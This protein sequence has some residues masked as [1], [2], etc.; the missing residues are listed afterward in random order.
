[1]E[2]LV[3]IVAPQNPIDLLFKVLVLISVF[4]AFDY[5]IGQAM[6]SLT[7]TSL[8]IELLTTL[9]IAA[10]FGFFVMSIMAVQRQLKEKLRHLA[11]TDQLTGL[12]NRQAF[13]A[14]ACKALSKYPSSTILM[15][16]VDHFKAV[17][18]T[19]G[20]FLGDISLR[21]VGNHLTENA[22]AGDVVGRL[23]GEEFAVLL[24]NVD[25]VTAESVSA[26]ICMP[27]NI[28]AT[29]DFDENAPRL[30]LT[31]SVGGVMALPGQDLSELLRHADDALYNAK[32]AGRARAVFHERVEI[33]Q[34]LAC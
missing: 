21:R 2:K 8:M 9:F 1:M 6:K 3:D 30:V 17:N 18:D 27:I 5:F 32:T 7:S 24:T 10:P 34:R 26:R 22:R 25:R 31:M 14:R 11:E 29:G 12:A 4:T 15:V 20:H 19:Y 33:D 13:L 28:D 23:G 16:D